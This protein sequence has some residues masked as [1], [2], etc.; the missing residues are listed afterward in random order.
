[1]TDKRQTWGFLSTAQITFK[2]ENSL[3]HSRHGILKVRL[4]VLRA[5]IPERRQA[6]SS[7]TKAKADSWAEEVDTPVTAYG[8]YDELLNDAGVDAV[9]VPLPCAMHGEWGAKVRTILSFS[10][11][12]VTCH[13]DCQGR[14][15]PFIRKAGG[16][17]S[18]G[19]CWSDCHRRCAE[20]AV[21]GW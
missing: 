16:T 11:G 14:Q 12:R 7:R 20:A 13:I 8:S 19:T 21:D 5:P 17:I 15:A 4:C 6:T 1:M 3:K 9:Y 2:N 10:V 18:I